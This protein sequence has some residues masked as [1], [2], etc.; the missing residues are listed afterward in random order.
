[1]RLKFF[2]YAQYHPKILLRYIVCLVVIGIMKRTSQKK[3][4]FISVFLMLLA[5]L[6][7]APVVQADIFTNAAAGNWSS[8]ATWSNGVAPIN[9]STHSYLFS[10]AGRGSSTND[11]TGMRFTNFSF[12]TGAGAYTISG[13]SLVNMSGGGINNSSINLQSLHVPLNLNGSSI[14][15]T[16]NGNLLIGTNGINSG[17]ISG[18]GGITKTGTGTLILT[19]SND[20]SG[21][22]RINAGTLAI[23][24]NSALGSGS[25]TFASNNTTLQALANLNI[26][27]NIYLTTANG[28]IDTG[29]YTVTNSG[30]IRFSGFAKAGTGTLILTSSNDYS[31]GARINAGTL[32]IS[33][34]SALGRSTLNFASNNVTLK[35]LD[36]I[37]FT[38]DIILTADGVIDSGG[39][40]MT[41]SGAIYG[42][43][44]L[45]KTGTG[46]LTLSRNNGYSGGTT[47]S[48]GVLSLGNSNALKSST[49]DYSS[50]GTISFGA[51]TEVN[52]G[53]LQGLKN[54]ALTNASGG[55][56]ALNVGGSNSST[57][58][59]GALSGAGALAK[60]GTGTL[61][62]SGDNTYSG[63]TTIS[64][65]ALQVGNG[66]TTGSLGSDNV[67]NNASL[68]FNRS[69]SITVSNMITGTG[70]LIHLG[71]GTT[72]LG[73][74]NTYT[75]DT[76]VSQG[77]LALGANGSFASTSSAQI[78]SGAT[79][80][81][82]SHNQTLAD[83]KVNGTLA[84][85]G[86]LTINGTLSGSGT[87]ISDTVVNGTHGPGNSPG[88]QTFNGNLTYT[89]GAGI[90]LQFIDNTT[91]NSPLVYDQLV[92]GEDLNFNGIT[93]LNIAFGDTGSAVDWNN[94]FWHT[95]QRWTLYSV[96]GITTGFENL[97]LSST[98]WSDA[99]G[100]FFSDVLAG[101][102]FSLALGQNGKDIV[103]NYVIPE[104]STYVLFGLGAL[105]LVVAYRRKVA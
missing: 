24:N 93:S 72:T 23:S 75:G 11:L 28:T 22:T 17:R 34:N 103:L 88:I 36:H 65:G 71:T 104:P 41:N 67:T 70:N 50:S 61:T 6:V 53:G 102:N 42:A 89:S 55:A 40:R 66:G 18:V 3:S 15:N 97:T 94:T 33:N 10:L 39:F 7:T 74:A 79:L 101:G 76:K 43:G 12:G 59:S 48:N 1:M 35:G 83:A 60:L 54:L 8:N 49:L 96:S 81:L 100:L 32:A 58:Y 27:N 77:T 73:A 25:L 20:Y 44:G 84:G 105:A 47:I 38:N 45:T 5:M 21:G 78:A 64:A 2:I 99:N 80:D 57:I 62:L 9:N 13:N 14:M 37:T 31:G 46:T 30:V 29:A 56:V 95:N 98:N 90:L 82:A 87:I 69:G 52:L 91:V 86:I 16:A 63:G 85:S 92:V 19:S 26:T 51:L 68:I 4:L